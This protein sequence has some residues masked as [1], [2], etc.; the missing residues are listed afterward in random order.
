M[1]QSF[2]TYL[3]ELRLRKAEELLRYSNLKASE[4]AART[5]YSNV[6][7]FY[8]L[9]RKYRGYYPSES[10]ARACRDEEAPVH[11]LKRK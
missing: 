2:S 1:G 11:S 9:F 5:G 6:N 4:I 8:T 10:K 7:Y 3:N